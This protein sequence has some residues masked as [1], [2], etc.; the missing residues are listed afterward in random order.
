MIS[1]I[2]PTQEECV[3]YKKRRRYPFPMRDIVHQ[4]RLGFRRNRNNPFPSSSDRHKEWLRG[5]NLEY[6]SNL[7]KLETTSAT[8]L[9]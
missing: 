1:V 8:T 2:L 4:G 3:A 6:S 9:I 7:K 5:Y